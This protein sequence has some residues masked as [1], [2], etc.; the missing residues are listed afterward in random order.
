MVE[1]SLIIIHITFVGQFVM[2]VT[3]NILYGRNLFKKK[4]QAKPRLRPSPGC[5]IIWPKVWTS[6]F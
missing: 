3:Y 2:I 5:V 1:S 4:L 6:Y